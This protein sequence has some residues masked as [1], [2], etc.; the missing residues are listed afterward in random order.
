M[1]KLLFSISIFFALC[2]FA[3]QDAQAQRFFEEVSDVDSL[4]NQDTVILNFA[5][6]LFQSFL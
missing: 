5:Y 2:A 3:P 4:V 1:K 6:T